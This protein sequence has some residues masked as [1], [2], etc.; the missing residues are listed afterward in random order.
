MGNYNRRL[1]LIQCKDL[2]KTISV[3]DVKEFEASV[4]RYPRRGTLSIFVSS[5]RSYSHSFNKGFSPDA[6]DWAKNSEYD[7]LLTNIFNLQD[8]IVNY[9]FKN[10]KDDEKIEKVEDDISTLDKKLDKKFD[11][12]RNEFIFYLKLIIIF[13]ISIIICSFSVNYYL[14][15]K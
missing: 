1:I 7:I 9:K 3:G 10:L 4:G 12:M 11:D 8:D 2:K 13:L 6:I 15:F 14:I 5:K